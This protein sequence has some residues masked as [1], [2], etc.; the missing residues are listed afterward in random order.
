MTPSVTDMSE[1]KI[2]L[3]LPA[4][5]W[6]PGGTYMADEDTGVVSIVEYMAMQETDFD[7]VR[8]SIE[9]DP[10]AAESGS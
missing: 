2:P 5:S 1:P 10:S 9:F 4:R 6:I 3:L 8:D 7:Q